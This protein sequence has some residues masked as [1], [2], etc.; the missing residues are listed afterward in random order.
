MG[1]PS[2]TVAVAA[3]ARVA[4]RDQHDPSAFFITLRFEGDGAYLVPMSGRTRRGFCGG[5]SLRVG[6]GLRSCVGLAF[7]QKTR[8]PGYS[9][10]LE[11]NAIPEGAA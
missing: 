7:R 2:S 6:V 5:P 3:D 1:T 11:K 8:L 4:K 10:T 9:L